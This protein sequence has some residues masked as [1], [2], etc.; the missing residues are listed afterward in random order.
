MLIRP[1]E[2]RSP[3]LGARVFVAENATLIGDVELG[4][5]SSIWFG[6]V[7]RGDVHRIR[8]GARTNIQ[9]N[10]TLHVTNGTWPVEIADEVTIGHGVIA[11]GCT[12]GRA[13]LIGMG[14]RVLDGAVIGELA[15]VGAGALVSEGMHV[16]PRT[17]V[18]GVPAKV[19]RE[20]TA[21]EL[22][23]LEGSWQHYVEYKDK[24]LKER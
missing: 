9:D 2:G 12:I 21:E 14:S 16:P 15:L 3:R 8:I 11:H 23:R 7:L 1:F 17:L 5:D 20:L 24:Y 13:A 6:T 18:V 4:D 19:K 10:C 22:A